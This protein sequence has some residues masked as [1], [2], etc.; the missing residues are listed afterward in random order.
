LA[1]A[2]LRQKILALYGGYS[3]DEKTRV[4]NPWSALSC[5]HHGRLGKYFRQSGCPRLLIE[6]I[7]G[8]SEKLNFFSGELTEWDGY[9]LE[10]VGASKIDPVSL[11]IQTGCLA[12]RT[13][14]DHPSP[15]HLLDFP[16]LEVRAEL[17]PLLLE[18][19]QNVRFDEPLAWRKLA[20]E[21]LAAIFERDPDKFSRAFG[22]FL[23]AFPHCR[24]DQ[25]EA[26]YCSLFAAA[27]LLAGPSP[28]TIQPPKGEGP[29]VI[30]RE[31]TGEVFILEIAC[32][33]GPLSLSA[34]LSA[35]KKRMEERKASLFF[36]RPA[37]RICKAALAISEIA[38]PAID[39]EEAANWRLE[40]SCGRYAIKTTNED[41][42]DGRPSP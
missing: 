12:V 25:K 5:F 19:G 18:L 34:A 8:L 3:W 13:G 16:N 32:A 6:R 21:A 7:A 11:M 40:P 17:T 31:E 36:R 27:M 29:A 10:D 1:S 33:L 42:Q 39:F 30:E 37:L 22:A 35:A 20:K 24:P 41:P 9:N 28:W 26:Y 15:R 38:G 4:L 23:A 14:V 2:D